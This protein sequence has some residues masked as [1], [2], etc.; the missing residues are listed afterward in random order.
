MSTIRRV[1]FPVDFSAG[2]EVLAPTVRKMVE[3]WRVDV[4]L[5]HVIGERQ[6]RRHE[7]ERFMLQMKAIAGDEPLARYYSCRLER[8]DPGD[9]ILE[10]VRANSVDLV[11]IP[12]G[13]SWRPI[14]SVA[15]QV[16]AEAPCPVWM[17]WGAARSPATAG[18]DAQ[19][20]CC[21][22]ELS[23]SDES[24][25]GMAARLAAELGAGLSVIHAMPPTAG[26]PPVYLWDVQVREREVARAQRRLDGLRRRFSPTADVLVEVGHSSV[27]VSRALQSRE[28]GLL[29]TGNSREA[30]FAAEA[31]CPVL[32]LISP[33]AAAVTA[34][35][36]EWR[37]AVARRSA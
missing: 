6:W 25:L 22:L 31:Q 32:R 2:C 4:T 7:L 1:L 15:D 3:A 35:E 5:L 30:I 20:V 11:V 14:G 34:A 12:A 29:V 37:Y 10:Y 8:G 33:A 19:Q 36:P 26:K 13:G 23:E 18:M 28:A 27:V 16:L 17:D 21:A 24:V 9:R